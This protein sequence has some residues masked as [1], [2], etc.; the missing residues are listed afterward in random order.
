MESVENRLDRK[1]SDLK[2]GRYEIVNL[3]L[4]WISL[5]R[6]GEEFRKLSDVEII[7]K[8]LTDI[9]ENKVTYES[10]KEFRIQQENAK[11]AKE[12]EEKEAK[13][14]KN[15]LPQPPAESPKEEPKKSKKDK[16]D[17]QNEQDEQNEQNEQTT[18]KPKKKAKAKD[19][20]QDEK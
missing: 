8:T 10:A 11:A 16:K 18:E 7:T 12:K 14:A 5:N 20:E 4:E 2:M 3:A 9:T 17:K 6:R 15:Q 19:K 13:E 1:M